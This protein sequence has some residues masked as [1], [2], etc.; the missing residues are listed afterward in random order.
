MNLDH[1]EAG[2]IRAPRRDREGALQGADLVDGQFGRLGET[3]TEGDRARRNRPPS[4]RRFRNG[5]I[6]RPWPIGAALPPGMRELD[7]GACALRVDEARD[8]LQRLEMLFAPGPEVLRRNAP[9][10]SD[11]RGLSEHQPRPADRPGG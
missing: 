1:P 3:I 9:L 6:S 5:A 8:P 2:G 7:A 4:A 11:R 10:G